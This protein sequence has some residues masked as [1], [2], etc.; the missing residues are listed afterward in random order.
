MKF[1]GRQ[2]EQLALENLL[3]RQSASM[4]V[5]K[6]RRRIGKSRLLDVFSHSF[7][8]SFVFAG[9]PPTK[10][11]TAQVQRDEFA[12]QLVRQTGAINF[13]KD[14]W[15][16]LF[17]ELSKYTQEGRVLVI[18][19]EIS[20]MGAEDPEFLGKLKN[21][22]DLLFC[23]NDDLVLAISG[24]ASAWIDK[25]ILSSTGFLGRE[26][27][28]LTLDELPLYDC[29]EFWNSESDRIS[30]YEK[31]KLLAVTGG[32]PRYLEHINPLLSAEDNIRQM[33]FTKSGIL[34]DEFEKIFSD[35]FK[36]NNSTYKK[37]VSCLADG[38]LD[39]Q[40]VCEKI[41]LSVGGDV[42][43]YLDELIKSGFISRDFTWNIKD[44]VTS[45]LSHY[46]L[47]DNYSRFYLNYILP[48]RARIESGD[49][50]KISLSSLKG[51]NSI[52]GL[53][54]ENLVLTNRHLI[55]KALQINPGDVICDNPFFQRKTT[56]QRGCQI[57]Y[58]IQVLHNT[59]Y[60]CEIRYSKNEIGAPIIDEMK[61][62]IE[63]LNLPK[64]FSYRT[65]LIHVNGVSEAVEDSQYFSHL[66]NL[67]DFLK[68]PRR[69]RRESLRPAR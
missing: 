3:K 62:K 11:T 6:G 13:N 48:N 31:L 65:V 25:N 63:R 64:R 33:C 19:D 42:S 18:L 15:S 52:M 21:A 67:S 38:I 54:I 69:E 4:V 29:A 17:W 20:W 9:L 1:I 46:R 10:S 27:L 32:I 61:Q 34:F 28:T 12:G 47:R 26:S 58:L 57:D 40:A 51:W 50:S 37:I 39:Q 14:D 59:L 30:S 44:G 23:K 7:Q 41:G 16:D 56:K 5:V 53:Q 55:K 36:E 35:L 2:E 8:R 66:I 60:I 68:P 49:M 43:D 24:S 22:W 45:S